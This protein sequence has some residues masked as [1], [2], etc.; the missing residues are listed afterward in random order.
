MSP[1]GASSA[2]IMASDLQKL[3]KRSVSIQGHRTS[4]ALENIFWTA[5]EQHAAAENKPLAQ[6]I[7]EI[8]EA[9]GTGLASAIRVWLFQKA[10]S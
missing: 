1:T 8:D 3:R 9:R 5:L 10:G 6:L 7:A 2:R 4:I